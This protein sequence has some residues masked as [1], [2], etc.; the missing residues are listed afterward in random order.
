MS[1]K[2]LATRLN[3]AVALE[4]TLAMHCFL[5]ETTVTGLWRVSLA[6][7]FKSL[8]NEAREHAKLFGQKV[9]ALGELPACAVGPV[10]PAQT[11]DEMVQMVLTLEHRAISLYATAL[12][13]VDEGDVAMRNML[14][15]HI[16]SEQR[17]IDEITLLAT[18]NERSAQS[19]V[20]AAS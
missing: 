1:E 13:A 9:V 19:A 14:E 10:A 8:G 17:H 3:E 2:A 15:D 20:R 7:L 6:P 4:H 12:E 18:G 5:Y 16:D 11:A